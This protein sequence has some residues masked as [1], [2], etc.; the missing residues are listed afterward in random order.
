MA[1]QQAIASTSTSTSARGEHDDRTPVAAG[2]A[3]IPKFSLA[4]CWENIDP[5]VAASGPWPQVTTTALKAE[6]ARR[7]RELARLLSSERVRE[8]DAQHTKKQSQLKLKARELAEREAEPR[9]YVYVPGVI[10]IRAIERDVKPGNLR[11][12]IDAEWIVR[13]PSEITKRALQAIDHETL[14]CAFHLDADLPGNERT[15]R[16]SCAAA[17][18][19]DEDL[20]ERAEL[21]QRS[22]L[23]LSPLIDGLATSLPDEQNEHLHAVA[24]TVIAAASMMLNGLE[25]LATVAKYRRRKIEL[26]HATLR[27]LNGRNTAAK[28]RGKVLTWL[29][30]VLGETW[31]VHDLAKLILAT[32]SDWTHPPC[33]ELVAAYKTGDPEADAHKL[34]AAITKWI[35]RAPRT[36][37]TRSRRTITAAAP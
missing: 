12:A 27:Q 18:R 17:K 36:R 28:W 14:W 20:H 7:D 5:A 30:G 2:E 1:Q 11:A 19:R 13:E 4:E 34:A 8:L 23:N 29:H 3:S 16:H 32:E 26:G 37:R 22:A 10:A 25:A 31:S 9:P 21:V 35:A 24:N 15:V 6:I 33:P